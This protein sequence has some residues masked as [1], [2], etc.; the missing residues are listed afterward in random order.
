MNKIAFFLFLIFLKVLSSSAQVK[1]G[2]AG[3]GDIK[4]VSAVGDFDKKGFPLYN[5][6]IDN[7]KSEKII[8]TQ[9]KFN[10]I[11]F[12]TNGI[13]SIPKTHELS[14]IAYWDLNIPLDKGVYTFDVKKPLLISANDAATVQIRL[15]RDHILPQDCGFFRFSFTLV[16]TGGLISTKVFEVGYSYLEKSKH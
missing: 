6:T 5:I 1:S 15:N 4:I 3:E 8:I 12:T 11:R 7:N 13:E 9:V 10:L 14:P 16:T 2:K